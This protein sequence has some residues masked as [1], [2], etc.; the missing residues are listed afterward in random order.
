MTSLQ[1]V[2]M[3]SLFQI[4][5]KVRQFRLKGLTLRPVLSR[6]QTYVSG[7]QSAQHMSFP[8]YLS[9]ANK[10]HPAMPRC[11]QKRCRCGSLRTSPTLTWLPE[12]KAR[13]RD[14]N[15]NAAWAP[16]E[17]LQLSFL[18]G[19][20]QGVCVTVGIVSRTYLHIC[21]CLHVSC[22]YC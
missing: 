9:L 21:I 20:H 1:A 16:L 17:D 8:I 5:S 14:T 18:V 13:W 11:L 4:S 6:P 7:S 12:V 10:W 2:F 19:G 15:M 22:T 3:G